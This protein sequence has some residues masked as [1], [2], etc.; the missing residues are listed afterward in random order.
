M[1]TGMPTFRRPLAE[2]EFP[3]RPLRTYHPPF[4]FL[5]VPRVIWVGS[6]QL[7]LFSWAYFSHSLD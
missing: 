2:R 4:L 5:V 6:W 3:L 1:M 7:A